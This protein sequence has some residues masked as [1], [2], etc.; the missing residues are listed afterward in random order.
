MIFRIW[1][2]HFFCETD[3]SLPT[4]RILKT[5]NSHLHH[6][7][8][9]P[10]NKNSLEKQNIYILYIIFLLRKFLKL[11]ILQGTFNKMWISGTNTCNI[12]HVSPDVVNCTLGDS[13]LCLMQF[14]CWSD[15]SWTIATQMFSFYLKQICK[16]IWQMTDLHMG[17]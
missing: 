16:W 9:M 10:I 12:R 2:T 4:L 8:M 14:K 5:S 1:F 15:N 7:C 6:F 17:Y 13:C 3:A 11:W